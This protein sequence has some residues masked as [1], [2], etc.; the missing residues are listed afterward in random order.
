MIKRGQKN[1]S[2]GGRGVTSGG[3]RNKNTGPGKSTGPGYGRG[4]GRGQGKNR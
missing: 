3:R 4:G 1:G 2:G